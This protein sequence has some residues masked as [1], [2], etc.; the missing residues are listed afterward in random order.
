MKISLQNRTIVL[1]GVSG[2]IGKEI[3]KAL[4]ACDATVIGIDL[5]KPTF[6]SD[7]MFVCQ[8]LSEIPDYKLFAEDLL[9][10]YVEIDAWINCAFVRPE[11]WTNLVK[12]YSSDIWS[13]SVQYQLDQYALFSLAFCEHIKKTKLKGNLVNIS[14]VFGSHSQNPN[15][16]DP[17]ISNPAI[18]Y[19]AIK[20]GVINFSKY[21]AAFYGKYGVRVN[22]VSPGAVNSDRIPENTHKK[23]VDN[24]PTGKIT[25]PQ[26]IA[27]LVAFLISDLANNINGQDLIIDGGYT[28]V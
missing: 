19:T 24:T 9:N 18:A 11:N 5:E 6:F 25:E 4:K 23:F 21:L 7:E 26:E 22:C 14:S 10:N 15:F 12:S 28:I 1:T 20:G 2:L 8:D 27:E 17:E 16:Y 13:K 3:Y